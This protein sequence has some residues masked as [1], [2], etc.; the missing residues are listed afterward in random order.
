MNST[1]TSRTGTLDGLEMAWEQNVVDENVLIRIVYARPV[2]E[3]GRTIDI[4]EYYGRPADAAVRLA[5]IKNRDWLV[6]S[7]TRYEAV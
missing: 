7:V 6:R 1:P 2:G 4:R 3:T 5:Y